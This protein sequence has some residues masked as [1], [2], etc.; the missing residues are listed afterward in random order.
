MIS[1]CFSS[2][3]VSMI[4]VR[5]DLTQAVNIPVVANGDVYTREDMADLKA[6]SGCRCDDIA[7]V[8]FYA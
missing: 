1:L 3:N 7:S 6:L 2:V 4:Y 8:L 5:P